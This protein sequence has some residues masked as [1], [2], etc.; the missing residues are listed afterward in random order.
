[1]N[2]GASMPL[3]WVG[4]LSPGQGEGWERE[5]TLADAGKLALTFPSFQ[6]RILAE[7]FPWAS[8]APSLLLCI[9]DDVNKNG[10]KMRKLAAVSSK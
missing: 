4:F 7:C 3:A 6:G 2:P 9:D 8:S 5:V 1:M 10:S